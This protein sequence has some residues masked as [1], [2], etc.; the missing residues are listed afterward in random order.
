MYSARSE[1][2]PESKVSKKW[3]N[4]RSKRNRKNQ[5][6][7]TKLQMFKLKDITKELSTCTLKHAS[8]SE[9]QTAVQ[10]QLRLRHQWRLHEAFSQ[11]QRLK[12]RY[13][14]RIAEQKAI[15]QIVKRMRGNSRVDAKVKLIVLR[16]APR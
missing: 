2:L 14:A 5:R 10:V 4:R 15:D 9:I 3:F 12:L 1:T 11:K 6:Y 13:E 8:F 16:D 7:K